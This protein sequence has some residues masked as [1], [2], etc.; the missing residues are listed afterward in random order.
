MNRAI[1]VKIFPLIPV[2]FAAAVHAFTIQYVDSSF[3]DGIDYQPVIKLFNS[4]EFP[5]PNLK[6][7]EIESYRRNLRQGLFW[8]DS[9]EGA[10]RSF[11]AELLK[12]LFWNRLFEVNVDSAFGR[13][14]KIFT[15][16]SSEF[17]EK[18][19]GAWFRAVNLMEKGKS[20]EGI[21]LLD[22]I[23]KAGKDNNA[24]CFDLAMHTLRMLVPDY[25]KTLFMCGTLA[26]G[27]ARPAVPEDSL[28]PRPAFTS[29]SIIS[30][31]S[32]KALPRLVYSWSYLL[33]KQWARDKCA[34]GSVY[35]V[36]NSNEFL[37]A[38][39]SGDL[40]NTLLFDKTESR[41]KIMLDL[42]PL[43]CPLQDY[44]EAKV[45]GLY[46]S[47]SFKDEFVRQGAYSVRCF[48]TR[49]HENEYGGYAWLIAFDRYYSNSQVF[50][51]P[52]AGA[53]A[54]TK[55]RCLL[56]LTSCLNDWEKAEA[57]FRGLIDAFVL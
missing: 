41:L 36:H 22:G 37:P 39:V 10:R 55:I 25:R 52:P 21:R 26:P 49:A 54:G 20:L 7:R 35:L 16:L 48:K 40:I 34:P 45:Q 5:D 14:D 50:S 2:F 8:I 13:A 31:T 53:V 3:S 12:G 1:S 15:R 17:P 38:F 56:V 51:R 42:S 6:G 9:A 19:E 4:S 43:E 18:I 32:G 11:K 44:V 47:L 24:L 33:S 46:D 29:F 27:A 28:N 30:E 23:V 57:R